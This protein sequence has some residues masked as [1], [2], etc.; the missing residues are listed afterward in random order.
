MGSQVYQVGSDLS[1]NQ[2]QTTYLHRYTYTFLFTSRESQSFKIS[3]RLCTGSIQH[4]GTMLAYHC[5]A[6]G[7]EVNILLFC[8]HNYSPNSALI[9]S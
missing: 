3:K 4:L 8:S 2:A 1:H 9:Q 6:L 5:F 7:K